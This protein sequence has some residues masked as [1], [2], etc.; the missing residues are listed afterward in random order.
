IGRGAGALGYTLQTPQEDRHLYT[1]T[2]LE[3][4]L[5]VLLGG[6]G[7]ELIIYGDTSTGAS[8]DLARAAQPAQRLGLDF[9]MSQRPGPVYS[10]ATAREVDEEVRRIVRET[11]ARVD[12]LLRERER[13]LRA[14]AARLV[15]KEVIQ[16]EELEEIAR[17]HGAPPVEAPPLALVVTPPGAAAP[18]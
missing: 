8:D 5:A 11:E 9:G 14:I 13:A 12:G 3:D 10:D 7:A 15:Q 4:R 16:R 6:R 18:D 2:E 17:E 1:R